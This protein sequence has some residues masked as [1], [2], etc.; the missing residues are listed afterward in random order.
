M[1]DFEVAQFAQFSERLRR[2]ERSGR[3]SAL[4]FVLNIVL[5]VL[6]G[7]GVYTSAITNH[8]IDA[9]CPAYAVIVGGYAPSTRAVGSDRDAYITAF[10]GM[11]TLYNNLG[12][13][14]TYPVVPPKVTP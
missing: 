12:C 14:P 5:V 8:R 7:V 10:T 6:V 3:W 4:G 9:L 2:A 1:N 11:R 13:S